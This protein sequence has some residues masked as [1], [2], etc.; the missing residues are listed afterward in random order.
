MMTAPE[1][2]RWCRLV[3]EGIGCPRLGVRLSLVESAL[4]RDGLSPMLGKP[5]PD[6]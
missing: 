1:R 5:L 2:E 6:W 3:V 4:W